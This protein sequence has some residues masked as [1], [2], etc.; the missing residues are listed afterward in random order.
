MRPSAEGRDDAALLR[1]I[2]RSDEGAL[3]ALRDRHAGWLMAWMTRRC[4]M[5]D[6]VGHAIQ[7]TFLAV[8]A[9]SGLLPRAVTFRLHIEPPWRSLA[10]LRGPHPASEGPLLLARWP[11]MPRGSS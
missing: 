8:V 9:G 7:D 6:V 3:A 4:A 5:P 1:D 10:V 2:A 11:A